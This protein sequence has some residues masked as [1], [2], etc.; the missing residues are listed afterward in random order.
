MACRFRAVSC[1]AVRGGAGARRRVRD[2]IGGA[3]ALTALTLLQRYYRMAAA[4][5]VRLGRPADLWRDAAG[6]AAG[7]CDE[8]GQ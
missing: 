2:P 6:T 5:A 3:R 8:H 4:E 7:R 1:L